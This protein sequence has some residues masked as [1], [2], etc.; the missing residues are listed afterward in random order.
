MEIRAEMA[1]ALDLYLK[2]GQTRRSLLRTALAAGGLAAIAPLVQGPIPAAGRRAAP[3]AQEDVTWAKA[4]VKF[5]WVDYAEPTSID[6][7]L[8]QDTNSFSFARNV[9]EPLVEIDPA[10]LELFPALATEYAI[11]EDGQTY[12][13]TPARGCHVPRRQPLHG[14]RRQGDDRPRAGDQPGAVLPD[15]QRH[16]RR[17]WSIRRR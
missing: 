3:A 10:K 2:S 8:V 16:R 12:T 9:Y 14:R 13:F 6:P 5:V 1:R 15:R 17:R 11:S 4:P 7:A